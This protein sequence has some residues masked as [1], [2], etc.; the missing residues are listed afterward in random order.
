[1]VQIFFF[2][3]TQNSNFI[4][5][6]IDRA[7]FGML[8]QKKKKF[9]SQQRNHACM[10]IRKSFLVNNMQYKISLQKF[11][12][13]YVFE[14]CPFAWKKFGISM[15]SDYCMRPFSS[16]IHWPHQ[17]GFDRTR[18]T[19]HWRITTLPFPPCRYNIPILTIHTC[20]LDYTYIGPGIPMADWLPLSILF[21]ILD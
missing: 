8:C 20:D 17:R 9:H 2:F 4:A 5:N 16:P 3:N 19:N 18:S 12:A 6:F 7:R 11:Y 14:K 21:D 15:A 10:S 13:F 1:M